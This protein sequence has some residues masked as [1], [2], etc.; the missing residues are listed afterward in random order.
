M[1]LVKFGNELSK[2]SIEILGFSRAFDFPWNMKGLEAKKGKR[3]IV[4]KFSSI[5][6]I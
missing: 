1:I 2:K 4:T 5:V 3:Q 6:S